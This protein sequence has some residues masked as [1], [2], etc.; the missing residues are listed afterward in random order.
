MLATLL[1][2]SATSA[3][4]QKPEELVAE[5]SDQ[6]L[7]ALKSEDEALEENE[8]RLYSLVEKVVLPHFDFR[9]MSMRVLGR[10]W[11]EATQEQRSR[12]IAQFKTL[13]VRTYSNALLD[14]ADA[15]V[16][17]QPV[18]AAEDARTVMVRTSVEAQG[19][20]SLAINYLMYRAGDAWKVYD[21]TVE[22][23]SLVITYR[24]SFSQ[25]IRRNG[26]D[27]LIDELASRNGEE[28][29]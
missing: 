29:G 23:V 12:F 13:L 4:L 21:V 8:Q 17:I 6:V 5:T 19:V 25:E 20:P 7:A 24:S 2:V 11:R 26:L 3:A 15:T 16:E 1:G 22:G 18:R 9:Q 28:R 14:Y 27:Q 10:H